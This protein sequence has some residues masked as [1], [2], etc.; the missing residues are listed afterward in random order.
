MIFASLCGLIVRKPKMH[1]SAIVAQ[2]FLGFIVLQL[3]VMGYCDSPSGW[4]KSLFE[5]KGKNIND[6]AVRVA[7]LPEQYDITVRGLDFSADGKHLAVVSDGEKINIWDWQAQRI[8]RTLEKEQGANDGQNTDPIR[9]SPDGR[10]FVAC[11]SRAAGDIVARIWNTGTWEN[12]HDIV[13]QIS[14]TGCNAM[15]F[16]PDGKSLIRVLDRLPEFPQDTLVIHDT[17]TW[18]PVWRAC[19]R[20]PARQRNLRNDRRDQV[21]ASKS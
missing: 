7:E 13:D 2:A 1:F 17:K 3:P 5:A 6:V 11:H 4:V 15:G 20:R 19:V 16:T 21:H 10:V 18:Q 9:F 12:A 14:G 8:V